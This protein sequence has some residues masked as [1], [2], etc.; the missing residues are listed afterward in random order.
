MRTE[1]ELRKELTALGLTESGFRAL[2]LLP[3]IEVAWADG[4]IQAAERRQILEIAEGNRLMDESSKAVVQGWLTQRP[5]Q[6]TFERG[7][8]LLVHV[9]H[10]DGK[11]AKGFSPET[12]E[13]VIAFCS[14]VAESAGGLLGLFFTVSGAE[15]TAIRTI[16][17]TMEEESKKVANPLRGIVGHTIAMDWRQMME[18]LDE[19]TDG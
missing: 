2:A 10:A 8:R 4:S 9:A 7:R 3:L 14:H 5:S 18:E 12:L 13:D 1:A 11:L 6:E 16:A 19:P 15:Q 17:R